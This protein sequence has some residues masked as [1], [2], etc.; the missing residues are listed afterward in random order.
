MVVPSLIALQPKSFNRCFV[1]GMSDTSNSPGLF[2]GSALTRTIITQK[3]AA[4]SVPSL[5][6]ASDILSRGVS[7]QVWVLSRAYPP[8]SKAFRRSRLH[9][10]VRISLAGHG[11]FRYTFVLTLKIRRAF[12]DHQN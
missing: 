9:G 4:R 3:S 1:S 12:V 11:G 7:P 5:P 6:Y 8:F 2:A 10:S